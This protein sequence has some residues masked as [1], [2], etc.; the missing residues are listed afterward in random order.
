M[1]GTLVIDYYTDV[2]CVWAWVAQHRLD[3]MN[4][5]WGDR[6]RL[7]HYY[8]DV[9]GD[10]ADKMAQ[11]WAQRG[12]YGGFAEHVAHSAKDFDAVVHPDIWTR[13]RP[14]TSGNAHLVIKAVE[15]AFGCEASVRL[16][17]R[18]RKAFYE[19]AQNIA[20]F[21][22]LCD[23]VDADGLDAEQVRQRVRNGDAMAQLLGDYQRAKA[24]GIKGS[25]SYVLDGGRQT[26]YGNVGYR[27]IH[28]NIEELLK[29]PEDEASWC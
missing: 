8:V 2:L 27:V 3:E 28:A 17:L 1:N 7:N 11:Q 20:D 13:V 21:D 10:V 9:F 22:V 12:G 6:I 19:S 26:L 15:L 16:A 23:L 29:R 14:A 25:P 18:I 5:Q 4:R 24:Q